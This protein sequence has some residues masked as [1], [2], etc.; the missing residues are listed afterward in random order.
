MT[1]HYDPVPLS[2]VRHWLCRLNA[3][4]L[5]AFVDESGRN[6]GLEIS[7]FHGNANFIGSLSSVSKSYHMPL[8]TIVSG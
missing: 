4:D 3:Q 5:I 1:E 7:G 6:E 2:V 8:D